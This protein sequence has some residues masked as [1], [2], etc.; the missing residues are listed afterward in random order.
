MR[1]D[2]ELARQKVCWVKYFPDQGNSMNNFLKSKQATNKPL[3]YTKT[4]TLLGKTIR[5]HY[6]LGLC[7]DFLDTTLKA[8]ATQKKDIKWTPSA[9]A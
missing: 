5:V 9:M 1:N 2:E 8:Q 6:N 7:S 4:L 3:K